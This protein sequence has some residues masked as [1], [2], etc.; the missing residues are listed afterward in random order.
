MAGIQALINQRTGS[1]QGNPNYTYYQ[2]ATNQY[3]PSGAGAC[4]SANGGANCIFHD[5]TT[6]DISV[7][8]LGSANCFGSTVNSNSGGGGFN[9]RRG[10]GQASGIDGALSLSTDSYSAAYSAASGWNFATGIGSI[11]AYNLVMNWP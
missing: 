8:C 3:G 10:F 9:G 2:L 6:G 11:D 5:V 1:A 4:T 7:N